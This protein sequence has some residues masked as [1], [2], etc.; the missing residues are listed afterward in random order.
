MKGHTASFVRTD[1]S[2]LP[3]LLIIAP[4]L[5]ID[6]C[7]GV[8]FSTS[9]LTP[10]NDADAPMVSVKCNG[11]LGNQMFQYA[12]AVGVATKLHRMGRACMFCEDDASQWEGFLETPPKCSSNSLRDVSVQFER[13]YARYHTFRRPAGT[14]LLIGK[15]LQSWKYFDTPQARRH[16]LQRFAFDNTVSTEALYT[17]AESRASRKSES[18]VVVAVHVRRTDK[19]DE[20]RTKHPT[21][22]FYYWAFDYFRHLHEENVT[23]V[24]LSDDAAWCRSQPFFAREDT[25][26]APEMTTPSVA[27]ATL[28]VAD[29]RILS[30]G[31]F[32]WWGA[33]LAERGVTLYH[34]EFNRD[35]L[36]TRAAVQRD[37]YPSNWIAY[38][39]IS[40]ESTVV[41][42]YFQTRSKHTAG[43]YAIWMSKTL[44]I[45]DAMVIFTSPDMTATIRKLRAHALDRTHIVEMRLRDVWV[46]QEYSKAFWENQFRIDPQ[47]SSQLS[48]ELYWVWLSKSWFVDQ[49]MQLDPFDS[50]IYVWCDIGSMR[51]N[52]YRDRVLIRHPEIV[53]SSRMLIM[54]MSYPEQPTDTSWIIKAQHGTH[55][56]GAVMAGRVVAWRT[57]HARFQQVV[58]GYAARELFVGEDQAV[59]QTV[60]TRHL[61]LC[62]FVLP[63]A[64]SGDKWFGLHWAL[65]HGVGTSNMQRPTPP[66]NGVVWQVWLGSD[67]PPREVALALHKCDTLHRNANLSVQVILDDDVQ[68]YLNP[69]HPSYYLLD[70]VEQSDYIR[71]EL[72]YRYGGFYL[73]AGVVCA[74]SLDHLTSS[75]QT[76]DVSGAQNR[77]DYP[78]HAKRGEYV[79]FNRNTLGPMRAKA[80]LLTVWHEG[81][82]RQMQ[83]ATPAL[84]NCSQHHDGQ[85]PYRYPRTGGTSICGTPWGYFTDFVNTDELWRATKAGELG[86]RMSLCDIHARPTGMNETAGCDVIHL[87]MANPRRKVSP[88]ATEILLNL[89]DIKQLAKNFKREERFDPALW[90]F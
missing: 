69:L 61:S 84:R 32:G 74:R 22:A 55:V 13:G 39:R 30:V 8:L 50:S 42:A 29:H 73:G 83:L 4:L 51:Q 38:P 2:A 45:L 64:V 19:L 47:N 82:M 65:Y 31:T 59:I 9:G 77:I 80:P 16:L 85:I 79:V 37:Y 49:A 71:T 14:N 15:Y 33:W 87:G 12:S 75:L 58:R 24:V 62:T 76:H 3:L 67:T 90:A 26:I 86:F 34:E 70:R 43:E 28:S 88:A 23:F 66:Q 6:L 56:A 40:S 78:P 27:M 10:A 17:V 1:G 53:P 41:T 52:M 60:C 35:V 20:G 21:A 63:H 25:S 11:R 68:Q 36:E 7:E 89:S 81:L 46:A 18:A 54:A 44:S 57:F 5:S 72:L 48:Y